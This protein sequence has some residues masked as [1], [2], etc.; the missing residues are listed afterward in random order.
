MKTRYTYIHFTQTYLTNIWTVS[1]NKSGGTLG[2]ISYYKPWKQFV[3]S[4]ENEMDI[5]SISCLQDIIH[6]MSQLKP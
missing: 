5:F 4:A 2:M 6:F 3:F 1:N